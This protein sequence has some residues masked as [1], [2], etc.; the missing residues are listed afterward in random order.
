MTSHED[1]GPE[2]REWTRDVFQDLMTA[3]ETM[4]DWDQSDRKYWEQRWRDA[5][6]HE[7][8]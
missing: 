2:D 3:I 4:S 8:R 1:T 7:R 6:E 5:E